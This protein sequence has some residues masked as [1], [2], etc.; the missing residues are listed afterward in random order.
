MTP[1]QLIARLKNQPE[2]VDFED[3]MAVIN[4]HY[5]Y[6]PV[7]FSN[8]IG[9]DRLYNEAGSNEGSC[10]IFAFA[11]LHDLDVAT[12]LACF[13]R[14]YRDDVLRQPTGDNHGN[15]RRFMK[16]GWDGINFDAPALTPKLLAGE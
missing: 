13:G 4:Q 9:G 2:S 16:Y 12:T 5:H 14:F 15:I 8:G 6:S 10:K 11:R 3:V 7:G 1:E